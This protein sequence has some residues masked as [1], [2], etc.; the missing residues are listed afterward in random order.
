MF[1]RMLFAV[2]VIAVLFAGVFPSGV[3]AVDG[4][5]VVFTPDLDNARVGVLYN[6]ATDPGLKVRV[7]GNG[8]QTQFYDLRAGQ[9]EYFSLQMGNGNYTV[10]VFERIEG[11][12]YRSIGSR[13][14]TLNLDNE[15]AA[16][17]NANQLI[18]WNEDMA[19]IRKAG[20]LTAGIDSDILKARAIY[21]YLVQNYSYDYDK[22]ATVQSGYIPD[23]EDI[24]RIQQ[25][26]CYDYSVVYAAMLRSIGI[27]TRLAKGYTSNFD[28]YHAW[29]EVWVEG[30]GWI[31]VDTTVDAYYL[32]RNVV[33]GTM[34]QSADAYAAGSLF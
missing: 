16:Y 34:V 20:E 25:G 32:S 30:R 15:L 9:K 33:R 24:A 13:E 12:R 11:T 8:G 6:R 28:G 27:P 22:A 26:I 7:S 21:D 1:R 5:A 17:L 31:V 19:I 29:N 18:N 14:V 23:I 3:L 4:A 2:L 10:T